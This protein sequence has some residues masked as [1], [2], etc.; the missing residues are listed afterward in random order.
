V[1]LGAARLGADAMEVEQPRVEMA[2]EVDP[3]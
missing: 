3:D 1:L 2:A